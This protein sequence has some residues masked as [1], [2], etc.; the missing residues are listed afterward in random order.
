MICISPSDPKISVTDVSSIASQR[1]PGHGIFHQHKRPIQA[2]TLF[3][4]RTPDPVA[5]RPAE[6]VA[7]FGGEKRTAACVSMRELRAGPLQ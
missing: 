5:A 1:R 4:L 7:L 3:L 2:S 6:P